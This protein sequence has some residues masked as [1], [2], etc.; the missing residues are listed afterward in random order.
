MA[1]STL[2]RSLEFIGFKIIYY[3]TNVFRNELTLFLPGNATFTT[4]TTM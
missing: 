1:L 2:E 3:V 4:L